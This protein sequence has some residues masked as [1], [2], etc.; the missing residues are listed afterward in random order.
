M[1]D[2]QITERSARA[3][4]LNPCG[5]WRR[6]AVECRGPDA[7]E[8]VGDF[9]WWNPLGSGRDC[10]H[11]VKTL[12]LTVAPEPSRGGWSVGAVVKGEFKWLAH[13]EDAQRAIAEAAAS[14]PASSTPAYP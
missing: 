5:F 11:L 12:K 1:N 9:F 14:L 2:T 10:M 6:D 7:T 8:S 4:G 13:G 3:I